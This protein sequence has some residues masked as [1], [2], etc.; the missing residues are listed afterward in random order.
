MSARNTYTRP[1]SGW[2][3]KNPYFMKY[4]LREGTAL[5][6]AIYGISLLSGLS[7][8]AR[9]AEAYGRWLAFIE[10]P[11]SIL[12]HLLILVAA[13]YHTHTWFSVAPKTMPTI[14]VGKDKLPDS[15]IVAGQYGAAAVLS[16]IVLI[17]AW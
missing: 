8:L 16:V 11:I 3:T 2:Y 13:L 12:I 5:L 6:L 14:K 9:G 10:S 17:I 4:M 7:A 1:M 15:A